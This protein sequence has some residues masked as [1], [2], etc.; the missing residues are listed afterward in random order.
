MERQSR[1]AREAARATR[2]ADKAATPEEIS[3]QIVEWQAA[4][5]GSAETAASLATWHI[6]VLALKTAL[7]KTGESA[8]LLSRGLFKSDELSQWRDSASENGG[9]PPINTGKVRVPPRRAARAME[10]ALKSRSTLWVVGTSM[11]FQVTI[12]GIACI[13][14]TRRDF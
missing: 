5:K 6:G 3:A 14:F 2:A 10:E 1:S 7:P 8:E 9:G 13:I 4:R 11:A 12:L